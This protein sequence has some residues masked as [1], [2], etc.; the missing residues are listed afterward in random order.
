MGKKVSPISLRIGITR[1]WDSKWFSQKDYQTKFLQ[2][3]EIRTY[4]KKS[5]EKAGV[6]KI[7]I[8]R[9]T[10]KI[11]IIIHA[12]KPGMIV[13]RGGEEIQALQKT[14]KTKFAE[15]FAVSVQEIRK[16]EADAELIAQNIADQVERRF[17]YRRVCKMAVEKAKESGVKGVKVMIGGRLNGVDIARRETYIEGT[18]PLHTLRADIDYATAEANTMYGV[19]GIK[20]WI[21]RGLVF[22]N[23]TLNE[24]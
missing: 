4:L 11:E 21:Y 20:V 17:P 9:N 12:A 13:G 24:Q 1:T 18:V 8:I 7:E 3:L 10:G 15:N 14:L 5:L 23:K 22:K 19:I 6:S 16:P 2:D